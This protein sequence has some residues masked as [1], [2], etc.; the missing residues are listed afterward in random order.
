MAN[1]VANFNLNIRGRLIAGF[2]AV[3][4]VLAVAVATTLWKV[5]SVEGEVERIVELRVPTAF[6]S[7]AMI[8][9]INASLAALRGWMLTGNPT[10]KAER[11]AVWADIALVRDN[12]DRLSASWTNQANVAKWAEF[13]TVLAEFQAAQRKVEDIAHTTDEQPAAKLLLT[14][15]APRAAVIM[16]SITAMID[17]EAK[18]EATAERKA[19]LGMMAD[20]RGTMGLGLANIRAFLLTGDDKFRKQFEGLWAKNERRFVDLSANQYLLSAEQ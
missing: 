6:A 4:L 11:A 8:N 2:A 16:K 19:L 7:A 18:L 12:M 17:A 5:S 14:E 9:D 20:V 1:V 13:K 3:T 10:F 15:A